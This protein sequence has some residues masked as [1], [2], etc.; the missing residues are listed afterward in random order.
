VLGR[1]EA[2]QPGGADAPDVPAQIQI[3]AST[4]PIWMMA[5]N[6]VMSGSSMS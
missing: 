2:A 5:V 1:G 3:V 6:A 4:A